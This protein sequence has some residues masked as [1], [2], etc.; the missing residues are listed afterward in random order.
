LAGVDSQVTVIDIINYERIKEALKALDPH[1][2][3]KKIESR[4]THLQ[5]NAEQILDHPNI[6]TVQYLFGINKLHDALKGSFDV[7]INVLDRYLVRISYQKCSHYLNQRVSSGQIGK[8]M[9]SKGP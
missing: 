2:K 4:F 9:L 3:A 1:L 6:S 5:Q 8:Q 7:V